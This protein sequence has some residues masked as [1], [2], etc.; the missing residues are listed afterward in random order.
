[1]FHHS[2]YRR[3]VVLQQATLRGA[4]RRVGECSSDDQDKGANLWEFVSSPRPSI[5]I[6]SVFDHSRRGE[7]HIWWLSRLHSSQLVRFGAPLGEIYAR[8]PPSVQSWISQ[9]DRFSSAHH[10]EPPGQRVTTNTARHFKRAEGCIRIKLLKRST[11]TICDLKCT[12][13]L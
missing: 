10:E 2:I 12:S 8:T 5:E 13:Y 11:C 4:K 1:M 3:R 7:Y 9:L 6:P